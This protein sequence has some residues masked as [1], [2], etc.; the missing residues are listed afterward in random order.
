MLYGFNPILHKW[1]WDSC[2][3]CDGPSTLRFSSAFYI[4]NDYLTLL[5][6]LPNGEGKTAIESEGGLHVSGG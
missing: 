1:L 2:F 5:D 3:A 4:R 6:S